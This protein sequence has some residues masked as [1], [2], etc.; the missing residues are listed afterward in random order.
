MSIMH[1]FATCNRWIGET[2][3]EWNFTLFKL[4]EIY[5]NPIIYSIFHIS[6]T[7]I[8]TDFWKVNMGREARSIYI[9]SRSLFQ[10]FTQTG[11][12]SNIPKKVFWD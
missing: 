8:T 6:P 3:L 10:R 12:V 11:L 2:K 5:H 1:Y 7:A 9:Y 4:L